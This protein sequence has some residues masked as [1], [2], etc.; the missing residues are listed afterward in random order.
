MSLG[1][2]RSPVGADFKASLVFSI[3]EKLGDG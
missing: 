1:G 2:M 3:S